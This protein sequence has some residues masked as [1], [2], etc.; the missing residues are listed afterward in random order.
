MSTSAKI[1]LNHAEMQGAEPKQCGKLCTCQGRHR[2]AGSGT[3]G[4]PGV[5]PGEK[6]KDFSAN[7]PRFSTLQPQRRVPLALIR[8]PHSSS[9]N[10]LLMD[11]WYF[12]YIVG[13]Q[14]RQMEPIDSMIQGHCPRKNRKIRSTSVLSVLAPAAS[15][16]KTYMYVVS[17]KSLPRRVHYV[18]ARPGQSQT[19][20][21]VFRERRRSFVFVR[22]D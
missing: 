13:S 11:F 18:H 3:T 5:S 9:K 6:N 16:A 19:I 20:L 14:A 15:Y 21:V 1:V 4:G 10:I 2:V 12:L 7:R 17:C 22:W 8:Q